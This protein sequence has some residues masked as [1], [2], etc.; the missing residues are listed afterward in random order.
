MN[1]KKLTEIAGEE[2]LL[3]TTFIVGTKLLLEYL[4][5]LVNPILSLLYHV[6]SLDYICMCNQI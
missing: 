2:P 1:Y 6:L 4:E 3:K 5:V